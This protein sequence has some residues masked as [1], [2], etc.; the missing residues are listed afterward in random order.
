[1]PI[2]TCTT[3]DNQGK[4]MKIRLDNFSQEE[5]NNVNNF[6]LRY[7]FDLIRLVQGIGEKLRNL[8]SFR[9]SSANLQ[10]SWEGGFLTSIERSDFAN[11][12]NLQILDLRRN[13]IGFLADD[14][15]QDLTNLE[16]VI[17]ERCRIER[18][19]RNLFSSLHKLKILRLCNNNLR[20][21]P[22]EIFAKLRNLQFLDLS[23][24]EIRNIPRSLMA[25]NLQL[26]TIKLN[27][28]RLKK[29]LFD[30]TRISTLQTLDFSENV[31]I[32]KLFNKDYGEIQRIQ[33]LQEIINRDCKLF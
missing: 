12:K 30:F 29:I 6:E 9:I 14:A 13:K 27:N 21:F 3:P 5:L 8:K 2:M 1:M 31:C 15:F 7:T 23:S 17:L 18:L 4:F 32:E 19:P 26:Q 25:N 11:M 10:Q 20:V 22:E 16:E 24:N 28:N 33:D